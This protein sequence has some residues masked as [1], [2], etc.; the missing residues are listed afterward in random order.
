[1]TLPISDAWFHRVKAATRD[2]VKTCGG[3]VRAGEI[4]CVSKTEISRWQNAADE[5]IVP[6]PAMLAL[7]AECGLP[8][9]TTVLADLSG[10]RLAHQP[11]STSEASTVTGRYADVIRATAAMM[12]VGATT[13]ADSKVT[14][15]GAELLDRSASEVER[16]LAP[17]RHDLA[18]I[19]AGPNLSVV[20]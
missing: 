1:M 12:A 2:L 8:I 10:R 11:E 19:K 17:L 5:G 13:M 4:A 9:V 16:C 20:K 7:E 18:T 3:V 15:A 14:A 6:L